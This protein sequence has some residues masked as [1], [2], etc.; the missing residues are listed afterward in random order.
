MKIAAIGYGQIKFGE[1]WDKG[2]RD[3]ISLAG[4]A[5]IKNANI[6]NKEIDSIITANSLASVINGQNEVNALCFE[7]LG[8]KSAI[9]IGSGEIAGSLAIS[10]A[11]MEIL[12]GNS[13][14]VMAL[15]V[16]KITDVISSQITSATSQVLDQEWEVFNGA[17]LASMYAMLTRIYM[18]KFKITLEQIAKVSVKNH[19]NA[20]KN[21][22]AQFQRE[23]DVDSVL[24][25]PIVASP[26]T[27]LNC[28]A[29]CDGASAIILCEESLAKK[30]A[31]EPVYLI[32]SGSGSDYLALHERENLLEM[33]ATKIAADEAYNQ[34]KIKPSDVN[35]AEV[36]DS[37]S[38]AEILSVEELGFCEKGKGIE[39]IEKNGNL[40]GRLPINP[41]GG[42]KACGN[43]FG[44]TGIRQAI[45]IITQLKNK[46]DERQVK[47]AK[48]GLTH[49][50]NG[51]GSTSIVNIFSR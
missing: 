2:L 24:K 11:A 41:S 15:G 20:L 3:L 23:I 38:I 33:K 26:L 40:N 32:G 9:S 35:L 37:F 36:H 45:E 7:E 30:Y 12:S 51:T 46:A 5:A 29:P 34:S 42:L 49:N 25:S 21:K 1:H 48:I 50:L 4:N 39:F 8:I 22:F 47:N 18:K 31:K 44:A 16:E 17:T 28:A 10:H 13:K 6:E 19:K 14:I 43:P 27:L